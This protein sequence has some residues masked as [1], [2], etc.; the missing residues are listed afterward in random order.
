MASGKGEIASITRLI[1]AGYVVSAC[2]GM[3][4][5]NRFF[6]WEDW[7]Y[8]VARSN[9]PHAPDVMVFTDAEKA[10]KRFVKW[11]AKMESGQ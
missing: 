6:K 8:E 2:G 3:L 7:C 4:A 11:R 1:R 9:D 10:A 5:V